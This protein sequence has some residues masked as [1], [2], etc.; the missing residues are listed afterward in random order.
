M[1]LRFLLLLLS[2][3]I[4]APAAYSAEKQAKKQA[5][6]EEII[7]RLREHALKKRAARTAANAPA[8]APA[9][10]TESTA[11]SPASTAPAQETASTT[12][13]KT[14]AASKKEPAEDDPNVL[15]EI[16]V[17][18]DRITELD[19]QVAKQNREIRREKQNTKP[20]VLD[21]TLNG[22]KTSKWLAIFGG[23]SSEDRANIAR[24]RVAMMEDERDLIEAIAQTED[25]EEKALL[26]RTLDAMRAMRRDLEAS[27]R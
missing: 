12:P 2:L 6:E 13:E 4:V 1:T 15:P 5:S 9:A 23:Q 25:P 20:T 16:Q 26:Q 10:S 11:A 22:P 18:K 7:A 19:K 8:A 24:E 17:R 27:L 21:E 3:V 14:A